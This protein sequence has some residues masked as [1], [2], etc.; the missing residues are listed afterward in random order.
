MADA[1]FRVFDEDNSG[2]LNFYEFMMAKNASDMKTSE[3]KLNWI[4]TAFDQ[5]GGGT[6]D[7][8]EVYGIVVGLF[9]MLGKEGEDSEIE[10]LMCVN[11]IIL[12]LDIDE[13]GSITKDEFVQ[14]AMKIDFI[15][16]LVKEK[17]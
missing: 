2:A 15:V 17:D 11:D 13:D 1:F 9:K 12:A 8:E 4:F 7:V 5:D 3:E 10:E 14:N 16:D 6:I